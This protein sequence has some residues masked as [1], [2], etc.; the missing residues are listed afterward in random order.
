MR[1]KTKNIVTSSPPKSS[2]QRPQRYTAA[3]NEAILDPLRPRD[4]YLA[5]AMNR[6][7]G[8]IQLQRF[9]LL[10]NSGK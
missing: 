10:K 3:E 7:V 6:T 9:R 4:R 1:L 5:E 2:N 8:A